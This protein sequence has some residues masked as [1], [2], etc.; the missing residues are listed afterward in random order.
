MITFSPPQI[1]VL[2]WYNLRWG[3]YLYICPKTK[4]LD[5]PAGHKRSTAV[6]SSDFEHQC[7]QTLHYDNYSINI[8]II[9][10]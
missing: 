6:K 2:W 8:Y 9:R 5:L 10:N 4:E 3:F 1:C 7:C